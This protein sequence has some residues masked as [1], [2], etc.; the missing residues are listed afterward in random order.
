MRRTLSIFD[1]RTPGAELLSAVILGIV[2]AVAFIWSAHF[3]RA[4][5][6]DGYAAARQR[7]VE[8]E[9]AAAGV[10][11]PRVLDAMRTVPRHEFLTPAQRGSAY[12]DMALPIGHGQTI[13]PPFVV[14][15]MTEQLDPQPT[16]RVL[17][18]GTG[19]GYQAAVLSGLVEQV[20]SIEIVPELGRKAAKTLRRLKV[21][22]VH[23]RVGDG[24][25]GWS[26]HAPFDKI[27][28][29]CSPEDIP[30]PLVEQLAEGGRMIV[31]LGE[32]YQQLLYR[33][34]KVNGQLERE[35]LESTFFVPM[36]G[37]AEQQRRDTPDDTQPRLVQGSFEESD[38][39]SQRPVGWYYVRQG[40][41]EAIDDVPDG[42]HCFVMEN[43]SPGRVAHAMQAVG[44]D[45]RVVRQLRVGVMVRGDQITAG[46][47]PHQQAMA[48]IEFYGPDRAPVGRERIGPWQGTFAWRHEQASI[49]VPAKARLAVLAVG[50]FGATGRM[51][52]DAATLQ[53]LKEPG[54]RTP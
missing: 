21:P 12:F 43:Q 5:P 30:K 16:D 34:T 9:I 25:F 37:T 47:T 39:E 51:A 8:T 31:P 42:Q 48:L 1:R 54:R 24:F 11:N 50:L 33:F 23:T 41:V 29:T 20:Y 46:E 45:G 15:F 19:S 18:I 3:V 32:R 22:N 44:V 52:V 10:R 7:L 4:E 17:E 28:V 27:M 14:A 6:T 53:P 36:T 2:I 13:S 40:R 26:E 38:G 49:P 35:S